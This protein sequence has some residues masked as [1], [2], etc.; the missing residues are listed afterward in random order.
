VRRDLRAGTRLRMHRML[1]LAG[2]RRLI[3][4]AVNDVCPACVRRIR[5]WLS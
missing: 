4:N 5:A 1:A 2:L 3:G